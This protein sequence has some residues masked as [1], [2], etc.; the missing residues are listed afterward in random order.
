MVKKIENQTLSA[1]FELCEFLSQG[2]L[3]NFEAY[4]TKDEAK[5]TGI[6]TLYGQYLRA[7]IKVG[8]VVT[9][10]MTDE[11]IAAS[12]PRIIALIGKQ[13]LKEY[14]DAATIPNP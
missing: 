11:Q 8:W 13:L 6:K 14:T 4:L 5:G 3:E 9:P 12:D 2:M 10:R 1:E 7:A